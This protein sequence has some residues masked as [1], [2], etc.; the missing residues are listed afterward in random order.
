MATNRSFASNFTEKNCV[1]RHINNA[2]SE[3]ELSGEIVAGSENDMAD[4]KD[5]V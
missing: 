1:L 5:D 3:M 2:R 4:G